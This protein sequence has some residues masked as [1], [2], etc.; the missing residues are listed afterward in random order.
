[1]SMFKMRSDKSSSYVAETLYTKIRSGVFAP[2]ARLP[3][4]KEL[5]L[6]FGVSRSVIREALAMLKFD[7]VVSTKQGSG[8][9]VSN[10]ATSASFRLKAISG[11]NRCEEGENDLAKIFELRIVVESSSAELAAV[12]RRTSDLR[13]IRYHLDLLFEQIGGGKESGGVK[14][15]AD[16]HL[17]I[18]LATHN[19]HLVRLVEFLWAN[20]E[21]SISAARRTSMADP[22]RQRI[23]QEQH[24]NIYLAIAEGDGG[25][26]NEAIRV[27]LQGAAERLGI[28]LTS[29]T[30]K[31]L[32]ALPSL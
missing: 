32:L 15:D 2:E 21:I 11:L 20:I 9:Y 25:K 6:F 27:H 3:T 1:M 17:A 28:D 30:Q 29:I 8:V 13:R 18:A 4:E 12:R 22:E 5:C 16:F 14:H 31:N 10:A 24:E 19:E 23:V 26:A 7:G